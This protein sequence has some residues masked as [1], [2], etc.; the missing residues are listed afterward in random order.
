MSSDSSVGETTSTVH[1]SNLAS[2]LL[3][4]KVIK[5]DANASTTDG[6]TFTFSDTGSKFVGVKVS[7]HPEINDNVPPNTKVK[8][9]G[10]GTLWLH[11]VIEG[12][13]YIEVRMVEL[14]VTQANTFGIA[15][16]TDVRIADAHVSLH[17][18]Q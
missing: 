18:N 11:R 3:T 15:V 8:I 12:N 14:I 5:A 17:T 10:L 1:G 6:I 13:N 9:S 16:G 4:A 7:G 2:K